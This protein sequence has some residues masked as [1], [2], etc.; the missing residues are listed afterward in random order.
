MCLSRYLDSTTEFTAWPSGSQTTMPE[1]N[2][3]QFAITIMLGIDPIINKERRMKLL[4]VRV[5][6]KSSL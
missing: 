5:H 2:L 4:Q 1:S 3:Q 6:I